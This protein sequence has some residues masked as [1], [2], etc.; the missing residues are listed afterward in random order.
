M[1]PYILTIT[2]NQSQEVL[3]IGSTITTDEGIEYFI[4]GYGTHPI[5]GHFIEVVDMEKLREIAEDFRP[6]S[7]D[8]TLTLQGGVA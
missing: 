4:I 3:N 8:L 5:G 6:D 1:K 7:L 2:D